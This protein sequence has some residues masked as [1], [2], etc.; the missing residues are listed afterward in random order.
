MKEVIKGL[1]A[2]DMN[3][4]AEEVCFFSL[5]IIYNFIDSNERVR[6]YDEG[7]KNPRFRERDDS[8]DETIE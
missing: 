4:I 7:D 3:L 8:D 6:D 1:I 2:E 5:D